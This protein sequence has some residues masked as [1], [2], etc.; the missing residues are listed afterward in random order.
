MEIGGHDTYTPFCS[1][2][3]VERKSPM[4]QIQQPCIPAGPSRANIGDP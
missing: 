2:N 1:A 3:E 4:E